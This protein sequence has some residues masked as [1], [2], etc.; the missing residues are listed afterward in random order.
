MP[1]PAELYVSGIK[2]KLGNYWAAWLPTSTFHLGDVG[3]LNGRFFTKVSSLQDLGIS[4]EAEHG[5]GVGSIDYVSETGVSIYLKLAGETNPFLP[6]IP[7]TSAGIG[8]EFSFGGAFVVQIPETH[9]QTIKSV[10]SLQSQIIPAF[11]DGRWEKNWAVIVRIIE[12]PLGTFLISNSSESKI[13]ISV[14]SDLAFGIAELGTAEAS[15][16]VRSQ[17]GDILK[18]L[19]AKNISPFF[20]IAQIKS[21]FLGVPILSAKSYADM[22]P[23]AHISPQLARDNPD[24]EDSLYFDLV[25]DS[26]PG[27]GSGV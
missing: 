15:L 25:L 20:Q 17:K 22:R 10:L 2:R 7:E 26:E 13:E 18:I 12:A 3:V 6:S 11:K 9:E 16:S 27:L 8:V 19:C 5:L 4:F 24:I 1:T 14:K 21:R 23:L